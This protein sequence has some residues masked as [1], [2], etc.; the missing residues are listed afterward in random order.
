MILFSVFV[1]CFV[2][3]RFCTASLRPRHDATNR[4]DKSLRHVAATCCCNKSSR[5]TWEN[6]CHSD[7]I[8]SLRYVA[9]IQ[10]GL[11]SCDISQLQNKRKQP[12]RSVCT[13]LRQVAA[14]KF[15][16]EPMRERQL[17]SRRVKC[18]LV[19]VSPLPNSLAYTE[20]VSC[21]SDLSHRQCRRGDL[22]PRCV[23][24]ICRIVSRP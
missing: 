23:A 18:E 11:Y 4:C 14:T 22:S 16:S 5:V 13:L 15:E 20:Q 3:I 24:V 9:R 17:F 2:D 12:C 7:R 8:L 10:T 21:R 1:S 6:H 19:H